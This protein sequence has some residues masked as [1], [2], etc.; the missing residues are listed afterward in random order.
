MLATLFIASYLHA[1]Q[2]ES[3]LS[4]TLEITNIDY[5]VK[6]AY[7]YVNASLEYDRLQ[8]LDRD[9]RSADASYKLFSAE[10]DE[11]KTREEF[12]QKVRQRLVSEVTAP[13][14]QAFL[15]KHI[16][17][18]KITLSGTDTYDVLLERGVRSAGRREEGAG[19]SRPV[20]RPA[21]TEPRPRPS[22]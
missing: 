10:Y 6:Q 9:S 4:P 2:C 22:A 3:S 11:S 5:R 14:R 12:Q 16:E 1:E 8:N 15:K 13:G 17:C 19:G 21:L 20:P 18:R 7:M